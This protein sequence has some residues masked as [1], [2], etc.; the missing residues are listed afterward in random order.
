MIQPTRSIEKSIPT[1][2]PLK[3]TLAAQV[4]E[5][6]N[7]QRFR[8]VSESLHKYNVCFT[9]V[10]VHC[11]RRSFVCGSFLVLSQS[12][13]PPNLEGGK[14]WHEALCALPER[15]PGI[16][17]GVGGSVEQP[18]GH[19]G[20][21]KGRHSFP[22]KACRCKRLSQAPSSG[23]MRGIALRAAFEETIPTYVL[24]QE[25]SLIWMDGWMV[26]RWMDGGWVHRWMGGWMVDGWM[27][28]G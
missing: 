25:I 4:G 24:S 28:D 16:L 2:C 10:F 19:K 8:A 22:Q 26:E 12:E 6:A 15:D 9:A 21:S 3:A 7:T 14:G 27:M 17:E 23:A 11:K 20:R 18:S 1:E 5:L 13:H